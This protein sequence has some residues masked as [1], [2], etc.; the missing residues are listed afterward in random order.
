MLITIPGY[1]NRQ[2]VGRG[3]ITPVTH[4]TEPTLTPAHLP[5][6]LLQWMRILRVTQTLY[7]DN[8]L[9][10]DGYNRSQTSVHSQML[11]FACQRVFGLYYHRAR[12]TTALT[13]SKLRTCKPWALGTDKVEKRRIRV[14]CRCIE[15][16]GRA[17][18]EEVNLSSRFVIEEVNHWIDSD[19]AHVGS[20]SGGRDEEGR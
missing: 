10:I 1:M 18:Q 8:M 20:T 12:P 19:W 16:N 15:S 11:H 13:A 17:V 6:P 4:R 9:P 5:H 14:D 3:D 2:L 7:R